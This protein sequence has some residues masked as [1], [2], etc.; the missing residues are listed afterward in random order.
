M[1]ALKKEIEKCKKSPYYFYTHYVQINGKPATT[2][3]TEKEFNEIF[4][5]KKK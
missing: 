1:K 4:F 2:K 5:N 3:Y